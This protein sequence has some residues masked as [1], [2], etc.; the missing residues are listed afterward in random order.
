[1]RSPGQPVGLGQRERGE[2]PGFAGDVAVEAGRA[3][4]RDIVGERLV[5]FVG[6]DPQIV[7]PCQLH[8]AARQVLAQDGAE[9]VGRRVQDQH[10]G[11]RRDERL[12]V[13]DPRLEI[14]LR[15][16][17]VADRD[18]VQQAARHREGGVARVGNQDLVPGGE[19][20]AHGEVQALLGAVD[21]V[22]PVRAD[23]RRVVFP[24]PGGEG[25]A[26]RGDAGVGRVV[27]LVPVQAGHPG[28][29][30]VAGDGEARLPDAQHDR[31]GRSPGG[32]GD[33]ADLVDGNVADMC[34]KLGHVSH[35]NRIAARRA[36]GPALAVAGGASGAGWPA[37]TGRRAFWTGDSGQAARL[38]QP[39]CGWT[40]AA[41]RRYPKGRPRRD[42][43]SDGHRR[44]GGRHQQGHPAADLHRGHLQDLHGHH[45]AGRIHR[46]G[47][48]RRRGHRH[49]Q[50]RRG[51]R[52]RRPRRR[53]RADRGDRTGPQQRQRHQ[54]Q[55][56][57]RLRPGPV[58]RRGQA[59]RPARDHPPL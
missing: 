45:P 59:G 13:L 55:R 46:D 23:R 15:V 6:D 53:R 48:R 20:Q 18:G 57:T 27:R 47:R 9:R 33:L 52:R 34:G 50:R 31:A 30:D 35:P 7:P 56:R 39:R 24:E 8:E 2:Y 14:V 21:D 10:L 19:Q 28:L 43:G 41:D 25:L 16:Q 11:P 29:E 36:G 12:D 42:A 32:F 22:D 1:M 54:G 44:P 5:A 3:D 38:D 17:R 37:Y 49:P 51:H 58:R 26:Q 40:D 4:M